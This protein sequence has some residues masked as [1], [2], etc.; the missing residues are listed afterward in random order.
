MNRVITGTMPATAI[1]DP[2]SKRWEMRRDQPRAGGQL[3]ARFNPASITSI[4]RACLY[5]HAE[6]GTAEAVIGQMRTCGYLVWYTTMNSKLTIS[7]AQ[8]LALSP[9]EEAARHYIEARRCPVCTSIR[10]KG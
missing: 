9:A 5:V 2:H 1:Q 7:P 10:M 4:K 6:R 8:L 3:F